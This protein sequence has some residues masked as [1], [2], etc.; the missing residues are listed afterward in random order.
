MRITEFESF[1]LR[2]PYVPALARWRET[3][4]FPTIVRLHTDEGIVGLGGGTHDHDPIR[5]EVLEEAFAPIAGRDPLQ[6]DLRRV[7]APFRV[8]LYDL[9]GKALGVPVSQLLGERKRGTVPVSYY[10]VPGS[11][12]LDAMVAQ[13]ALAAEEGYRTLSWHALDCGTIGSEL[14]DTVDL[15]KAIHEAVGDRLALRIDC[16]MANSFDGVVKIARQLDGYNIECF[17]DGLRYTLETPWDPEAYRRLKDK[18]E[19]P[20]AWHTSD[21]GLMLEG[22][23]HGAVDY[24]N[25][26][27]SAEADIVAKAA[28]LSTF[29]GHMSQCTGI[30]YVFAMHQLSTMETATVPSDGAFILAEDFIEEPLPP[31]IDGWQAL[32]EG[33]GLG[34]TLDEEALKEY[35]LPEGDA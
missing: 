19:I 6:L 21:L 23:R 9:V 5:R 32:P 12:P 15:V 22:Y 26:G 31:V 24:C 33:P 18:T 2:G 4:I 14:A 8:A 25:I 1:P 28:G 11:G 17:E 3:D 20:Q 34:V 16:P 30:Q 13:A 35:A 27:D 7:A 29:N 10:W